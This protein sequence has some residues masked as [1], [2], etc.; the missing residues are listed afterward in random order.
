MT[1]QIPENVKKII[2]TLEHN[3]YEAYVV[4]GCVRDAILKKEPMDWDITTSAKPEQTKKFFRRTIDTGIEHGT[5]TIMMGKEGYEVTTYR[6]DG[7][8]EDHRRPKTVSFTASLVEDLKRRD[9][10]MNAMA[11]NEK[12]GLQD[13][14]F[15]VLDLEKGLIR[16]VG[17]AEER[18]DE[19]ALRILRAL[20]FAS[21]LNFIIEDETKKAMEKKKGFLTKIS[22]ERIQVELTKLLCSNYPEKLLEGKK[23]GITAIIL[24][25]FDDL[26]QV[27]DEECLF[28]MLKSVDNHHI[29]RYAVLFSHLSNPKIESGMDREGEEKVKKILKG[30]KFDNDTIKKVS[31]LVKYCFY[32]LEKNLSMAEVRWAVYEVGVELFPFLLDVKKSMAIGYGQKEHLEQ[33]KNVEQ[34]YNDILEKN[35]CVCLKQLALNGQDLKKI[36]IV[37]GIKIG[38]TLQKLLEVVLEQPEKNTKEKLLELINVE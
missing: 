22:V 14:F 17:I 30:L 3:G 15:G 16:C 23:L 10:T 20:R 32:P 24:P 6:V 25:E 5:V 21:Q 4:G 7:K 9:F 11:Y 31:R 36:G 38:E 37:E 28:T 29:L 34:I 19:D 33:L 26:L 8:Y 2:E 18:F 35:Q 1:I 27:V 12:N 13:P